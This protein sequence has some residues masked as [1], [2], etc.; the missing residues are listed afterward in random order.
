MDILLQQVSSGFFWDTDGWVSGMGQARVFESSGKAIEFCLLHRIGG[1]RLVFHFE[2]YRDDIYLKPFP[3]RRYFQDE[4]DYSE[5]SKFEELIVIKQS[6]REH[7]TRLQGDID[8]AIADLDRLSQRRKF[9][10]KA[11]QM[12]QGG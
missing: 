8:S 3:P 11:A 1:V 7:G 4:R 2:D 12:H 5:D 6:L 9:A 10:R